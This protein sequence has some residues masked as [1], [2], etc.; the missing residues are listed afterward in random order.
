MS[1]PDI[2]DKL[3]HFTRPKDDWDQAY[4]NLKSIMRHGRI[5]A[6]NNNIRGSFS[7]VC[8]TEAPISSLTEG[9]V[10][11]NGYSDYSPFGII[12]TKKW[13]YDK[14]GRPVIYQSDTEYDLLPSILQWRHMRYEPPSVD[15]LW[16]R[17]WRLQCEGLDFHSND[18]GIIVPNHEWAQHMLHEH[19]LEQ[20]YQVQMYSLVL[21]EDLALQYRENFPW[22]IYPL[23]NHNA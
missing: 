7:C 13:I 8:F 6:G 18:A 14:G 2:S 22:R 15:F 16:E 9:F 19:D 4:Q 3:I 1:R 23:L 11:V 10:N 21:D 5:D 20:D 12:F 17:E